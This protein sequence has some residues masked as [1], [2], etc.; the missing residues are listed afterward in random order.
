MRAQSWFTTPHYSPRCVGNL[1]CVRV[2]T[3]VTC[4]DSSHPLLPWE[5]KLSLV[6]SSQSQVRVISQVT[7]VKSCHLGEI[8]SQVKSSQKLRLESTRVRVS[9]LTCY[10]C[11]DLDNSHVVSPSSNPTI[12]WHFCPSAKQVIHIAAL[13]P[14]V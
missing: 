12:A 3:R 13:D 11:N 4:N 5:W 10:N 9:D 6:D 7:R 14:D 1:V 8:S 2:I